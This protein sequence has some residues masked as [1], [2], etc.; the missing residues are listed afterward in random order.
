MNR[1]FSKLLSIVLALVLASAVFTGCESSK[2]SDVNSGSD[3]GNEEKL[4]VITSNF[5]PYDFLREIGKDKI[6]LSMLITP[7]AE[8]HSYEPTP[9]DIAA[10]NSCDIFVYVGG[11]SDSWVGSLIDSG[12]NKNMKV[13]TMMDCVELLEEPHQDE[14]DHDHQDEE[15]EDSKDEHVWTSPKNAM[16]IVDKL[17]EALCEADPDNSDYYRENSASYKEKLEKL[18]AD[19]TEVTE[20]SKRKTLVFG[21]RFPFNYL[22]NAY[23]LDYI[24]AYPGCSTDTDVSSAD[25][26]RIIDYVKENDIPVVFY[27]E[28][29]SGNIADTICE[30]TGAKKLLLH[31][32]HNLSKEDFE[33][34][35][36]YLQLMENNLKNI[37]EALN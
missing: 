37:E 3:S 10:V 7:G 2:G 21:D 34:G 32:C 15:P 11:K 1:K 31:S 14:E 6:D 12:D 8:S 24:S 22:V 27:L 4:S 33:N 9:K 17:T 25:I 5:P 35:V 23:G 30:A 19:F 13:V 16:L 28:L 20:S 36:T 29:S 18:D 26:A